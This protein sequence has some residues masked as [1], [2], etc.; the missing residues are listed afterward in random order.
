MDNE[1]E[2]PTTTFQVVH[3]RIRNKFSGHAA[4]MQAIEKILLTSR[5]VYPIYTDQYGN[6]LEDLIGKDIGYA[7]TEAERMIKEALLADTRV[8]DVTIAKIEPIDSTSLL[9]EGSCV[10]NYGE[11]PIESEVQIGDAK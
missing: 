1:E 8:T 10:T 4:M 9:I 7:K 6:D 2:Q 3:G 11:V 5:F